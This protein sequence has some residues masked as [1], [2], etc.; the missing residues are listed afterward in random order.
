VGWRHLFTSIGQGFLLATPLQIT[1]AF[2]AITND[3][4]LYQPQIVRKV[5]DSEKNVLEEFKPKIIR[6]L[7]FDSQ[8]LQI[9][10]EGMREAVTYGS[11]VLLNTLPVKAA[12]KTGT[13]QTI[14]ENYY[15][16]WITVFAPYEDPQI[17]LTILIENVRGLR[18]PVLP[19]AKNVLQW[20]FEKK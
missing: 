13:A 10:R 17:V 5:V 8:N 1:S 15:H 12:A 16:N 18:V 20:H 11:A 6:E 19:V 3:G 4:K 7:P 14:R 9:V 2:S